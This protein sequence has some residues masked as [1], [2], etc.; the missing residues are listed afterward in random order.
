MIIAYFCIMPL[1][2]TNTAFWDVDITKMDEGLH[3]DFIITRVFEYG[4]LNDLK[5]VIKYYPA[6]K[7]EE[8]LRKKRGID[9]KAIALARVAGYKV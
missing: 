4:L 9:K 2:L 8:A 6:I 5:L 1:L 3:A 7:I